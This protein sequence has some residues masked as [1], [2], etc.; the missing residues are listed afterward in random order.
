MGRVDEAIGQFERV[1]GIAGRVPTSVAGLGAAYAAAGR[2]E[3][4]MRMVRELGDAQA[5]EDHYVSPRDLALVQTWLGQND[6]ALDSLERACQER[7]AWMSFINVDPVWD[8][9][10]PAPRF[11]AI[12]RKIGLS[13]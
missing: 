1:L 6:A 9:L 2:K 10:R 8:A 7:A 12:V 3:D 13:Q 5:F 4:A 11:Q